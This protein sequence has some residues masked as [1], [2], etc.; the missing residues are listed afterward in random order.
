[1]ILKFKVF[2]PEFQDLLFKKKP[3]FSALYS[4]GCLPHFGSE[5]KYIHQTEFGNKVRFQLL[6]DSCVPHFN[7]KMKKNF[8]I[9]PHGLTGKIP[10]Q[11]DLI[12]RDDYVTKLATNMLKPPKQI[13]SEISVM[14]LEEAVNMEKLAKHIKKEKENFSR[15]CT[16]I[17]EEVTLYCQEKE[18]EVHRKLDEQMLVYKQYMEKMKNVKKDLETKNEHAD[19]ESSIELK[20]QDLLLKIARLFH[21]RSSDLN[22]SINL[23]DLLTEKKQYDLGEQYFNLSQNCPKIKLNDY[24]ERIITLKNLR[25]MLDKETEIIFA[26][27]TLPPFL[28]ELHDKT[29]KHNMTVISSLKKYYL[30]YRSTPSLMGM[31]NPNQER[32]ILEGGEG[33]L[34]KFIR[35]HKHSDSLFLDVNPNNGSLYGGGAATFERQIRTQMLPTMKLVKNLHSLRIEFQDLRKE[36]FQKSPLEAIDN[37]LQTCAPTLENLCLRFELGSLDSTF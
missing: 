15:V 17:I 9:G 28:Q 35:V 14:I 16:Q 34:N 23:E 31:I 6:C 37:T 36:H 21:N 22:F 26:P 8:Q 25:S 32:R 5:L 33:K 29:K 30:I 11:L 13:V 2:S 24:S 19:L 10:N 18:R 1:M 12:S 7:I 4:F 20:K 27:L 3:N